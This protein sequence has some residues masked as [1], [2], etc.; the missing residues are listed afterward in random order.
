MTNFSWRTIATYIIRIG[1]G[2]LLLYAAISKLGVFQ[3]DAGQ[4]LVTGPADFMQKISYYRLPFL[5]STFL[6][7]LAIFILG[8]EVM[9]GILLIAGVWL[10]QVA[11]LAA[12]LFGIFGVLVASALAR[13]LEIDCGCFGNATST[14]TWKTLFR[15]DII[16]FCFCL[17]LIFLQHNK[18]AL[19]QKI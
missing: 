2:V 9:L 11:R 8:L 6:P 15:D 1:L 17:F 19:P 10:K 12:A 3:D 7:F 5:P 16:P 18:K 13:N 4:R 14:A